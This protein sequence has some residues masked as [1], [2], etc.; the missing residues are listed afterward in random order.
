LSNAT[1]VDNGDSAL[2]QRAGSG[3][4]GRDLGGG[5]RGAAR[6]DADVPAVAGGSDGD[7][8]QRTFDQHRPGAGGQGLPGRLGPQ[9]VEQL[10]LRV[11]RAGRAVEVLRDV[12]VL[13]E[14][15]AEDADDPLSAR[16][17]DREHQPVPEPVDHAAVAG[18]QADAGVEHL[19]V[20]PAASA[21]VVG[22]RGPAGRGV[23]ELIA[24]DR[25]RRHRPGSEHRG[26]PGGVRGVARVP[27]GYRTDWALFTD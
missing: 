11:Q 20:G 19:G 13:G 21:Q 17:A 16:V 2:D 10:A 24:G 22:E 26:C 25:R 1:Y 4:Q 18:A 8:V 15:P 27:A 5:E 7:G 23:A 3:V 12:G 6:G 14:R 9:P